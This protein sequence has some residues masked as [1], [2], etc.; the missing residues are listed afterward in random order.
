MVGGYAGLEDEKC[1][2]HHQCGIKPGESLDGKIILMHS[3]YD[4]TAEAT[5]KLVPWL[6][7]K[8][9]QTV[10]VSELIKYRYGEDGQ[11][12]KVYR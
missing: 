11:D 8:G 2:E 12:G 3:L 7:E 9:Y 6:K 5:K 10:T 1:P 4:T